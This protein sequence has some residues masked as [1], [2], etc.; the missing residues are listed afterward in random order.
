MKSPTQLWGQ[1]MQLRRRGRFHRDLS[2]EVREH[3]EEKTEE[4]IAGAAFSGSQT[5]ES[6]KHRLCATHLTIDE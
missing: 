3:L 4:L 2:N 6:E 1:W 5:A